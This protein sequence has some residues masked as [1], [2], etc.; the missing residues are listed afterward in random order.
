MFNG[1]AEA[2][3]VTPVAK[4]GVSRN[5]AILFTH[6]HRIPHQLSGF[7][8]GNTVFGID[9][10]IIPDSRRMQYRMVVDFCN[11]GAV[12]FAGKSN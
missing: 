5:H 1:M 4:G 11:G 2:I 8:P 12:F 9:R 6:Q 7:I 3:K 10:L